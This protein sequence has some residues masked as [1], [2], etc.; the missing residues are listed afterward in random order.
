MNFIKE[1]QR[2]ILAVTI[3][4]LIYFVLTFVIT[5]LLMLFPA[6]TEIVDGVEVL[7]PG[8]GALQNLINYLLLFTGIFLSI[9]RDII[10]DFT[11][12]FSS[13][14][15][16]IGLMLL[17]GIGFLVVNILTGQV[18]GLLNTAFDVGPSVNQSYLGIML[19]SEF[20]LPFA[21]VAIL[22][23]P[24]VEEMIFRKSLFNLIKNPLFAVIISSILFAIIHVGA[25][26]TPLAFVVNSVGYLIPGVV[27]GLLYLRYKQNI[28]PI[29][30][31]HV[32]NNLVSVLLT[33]LQLSF[34]ESS[35]G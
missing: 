31:I 24:I 28:A 17:I 34:A 19:Q 14:K 11:S 33:L 5:D 26:P 20:G 3:Y 7:T 18:V 27:F 16:S 32:I 35:I 12:F 4:A 13:R 9:K 10:D 29:M 21:F 22:F 30:V 8:G 15:N 6:F 25:E 2:F 1:K 23:G